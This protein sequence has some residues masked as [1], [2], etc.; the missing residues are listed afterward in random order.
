M[1]VAEKIEDPYQREIFKGFILNDAVR[2]RISSGQYDEAIQIFLQTNPN[3]FDAWSNEFSADRTNDQIV[4]SKIEILLMLA[5]EHIVNHQEAQAAEVIAQVLQAIDTLASQETKLWKILGI[6]QLYIEIKQ[7]EKAIE[8]LESVLEQARLQAT[9]TPKDPCKHD[10]YL[11]IQEN[12]AEGL[13]QA[14]QPE[15]AL[16]IVQE[17]ETSQIEL[18][19]KLIR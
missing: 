15:R 10:R 13:A 4:S 16:Q 14:G 6:A 11:S 5:A 7:P 18:L 1:Q 12:V 19:K 8:L 9:F 17:I 3:L 2:E